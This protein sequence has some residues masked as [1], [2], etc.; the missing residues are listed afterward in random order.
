M[1]NLYVLADGVRWLVR[2]LLYCT[3]QTLDSE[4]QKRWA[5][6]YLQLVGAQAACN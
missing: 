6:A 3:I 5:M 2:P 4:N 1:L